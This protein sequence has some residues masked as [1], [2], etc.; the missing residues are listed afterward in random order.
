MLKKSLTVVQIT[1]FIVGGFF[2]TLHYF[3]NY[4]DV[5][6]GKYNNCTQNPDKGLA[7]F[8]NLIFLYYLT[9][10]FIKFFVESYI[11]PPPPKK[12]AKKLD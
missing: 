9:A 6:T 10:L 12:L 1:Q 4:F 8:F 7:A 11:R 2:A 5:A 3:I